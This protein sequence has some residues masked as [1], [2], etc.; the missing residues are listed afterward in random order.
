MEFRAVYY[1]G[2]VDD[3]F[4]L[5]RLHGYLIKFKDY[6]NKCHLKMKF[7]FEEGKNG[8][9]SFLDVGVSRK[10]NKF[11]TMVYHKPTFSGVYMDFD[12]FLSTTYKFGKIYIL[13]FTCFSI[14]SNWN[15][16]HNEL[17]FPEDKIFKNGY[18]ISFID[19]CFK[20]FLDWL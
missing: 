11:V 9:L 18:P 12:S 5:F 16:F 10:G 3:M 15:N 20:T 6:L 19:K 14:S 17:A 1:R 7:S 2:Y 13:A 4:V 8:T